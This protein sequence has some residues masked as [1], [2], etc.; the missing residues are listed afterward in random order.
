MTS[1]KTAVLKEQL[2]APTFLKQQV[3]VNSKF[4]LYSR[5]CP[6]N[7]LYAHYKIQPPFHLDHSI[8]LGLKQVFYLTILLLLEDNMQYLA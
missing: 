4:Y 2:N 3:A 8:S 7:L 5:A 1:H 6:I